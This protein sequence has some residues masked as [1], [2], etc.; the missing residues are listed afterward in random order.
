MLDIVLEDGFLERVRQIGLKL[1]Q[2]L[3]GVVDAYPE[4]IEGIRGEGLMLGI[5]CRVSNSDV[6]AAARAS[7]LLLVPAGDNVVRMLPPLIVGEVEID[8]AIDRLEHALDSLA[9]RAAAE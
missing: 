8:E 1:K 4:A 6:A 3:A 7:G 9:K 5:K 2:K